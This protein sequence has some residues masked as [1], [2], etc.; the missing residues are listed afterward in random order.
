MPLAL[1]VMDREKIVVFLIRILIL[2]TMHLF[3]PA[4]VPIHKHTKNSNL[5]LSGKKWIELLGMALMRASY[6]LCFNIYCIL[7]FWKPLSN[8]LDFL[9]ECELKNMSKIIRG[10]ILAAAVGSATVFAIGEA[11][12]LW[13]ENQITEKLSY[14]F[15]ES[16]RRFGNVLTQVC[17]FKRLSFIVQGSLEDSEHLG[18]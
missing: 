4:I 11:K 13:N 8:I 14:S 5:C 18:Y 6:Y 7:F 16:D 1:W 2:N 15:E 10:T 3:W 9:R 12:V 17:W